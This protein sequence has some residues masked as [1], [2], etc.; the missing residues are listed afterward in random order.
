MCCILGAAE[1]FDASLMLVTF[2]SERNELLIL[3]ENQFNCLFG[4]HLQWLFS[5]DY[6]CLPVRSG[7]LLCLSSGCIFLAIYKF[8]LVISQVDKMLVVQQPILPVTMPSPQSTSIGACAKTANTSLA[9]FAWV[10]SSIYLAFVTQETSKGPWLGL[11]KGL[12]NIKG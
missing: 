8:F 2:L 7:F 12:I 5:G 1:A 3:C 6:V 4:S 9:A 11:I 10:L